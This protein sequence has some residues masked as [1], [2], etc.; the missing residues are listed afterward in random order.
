MSEVLHTL[1]ERERLALELRYREGMTF[2]QGGQKIGDVSSERVQT[3]VQTAMRKLRYLPSGI[4]MSASQIA[5][6]AITSEVFRKKK[7][8]D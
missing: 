8:Y 2:R 6:S 1:S 4:Y 3:I 5:K 7:C